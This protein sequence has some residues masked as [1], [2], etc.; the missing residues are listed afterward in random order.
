VFKSFGIYLTVLLFSPTTWSQ[1]D[2]KWSEGEHL[3]LGIEGALLACKALGLSLEECPSQ[4]ILRADKKFTFQYG[5]V[6]TS[7]DYYNNPEEFFTDKSSNIVKIMKC[8][9]NQKSH[10]AAQRKSEIDYTSCNSTGVFGMPGYL[11][12]VSQN[13]NHFG[14]NNMVAYIEFH[15]Q[16]LRVAKKSY[17]I[18]TSNPILS[19]QL[20]NKAMVLNGYADHYL[21]DA[22][23]SGHIRIP[24]IQIKDWA[25]KSLPGALKSARGDLLSM[26]LHNFESINL[27]SGK[28]EGFRVQ[29]SRGDVWRTRGD[30]SLNLLATE[31]DLTLVLPRQAVAESFKDILIAANFGDLP[32]GVYQASQF[33]PFQSDI[34][35]ITKLSPEHQKVKRQGDVAWL[36]FSSA[37]MSD[38][39]LFFKSDFARMLDGLSGIFIKFRQDIAREQFEKSE[40]K[41]RLPEKYLQAISM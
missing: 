39:F 41:R 2:I 9:Y 1:I 4:R 28:E 34:P 8:A 27:R 29:N 26:F 17:D 33:V 40:L 13:Y 35:L 23:A 11:E 7:A 37:P 3:E 21:T 31:K 14:W 5:E 6:M 24:R 22:F 18:K 30:G 15:G 10:Q 32:E 12:V 25:T 19:R 16:A 38:K 36:I 20:L